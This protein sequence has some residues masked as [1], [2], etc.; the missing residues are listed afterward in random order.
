MTAIPRA[1]HDAGEDAALKGSPLAV[2]VWLWGQ[3]EPHGYRAVVVAT[4]AKKLGMKRE[5]VGRALR[6][7]TAHGYLSEGN[8]DGPY[9]TFRMLVTRDSAHVPLNGHRHAS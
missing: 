4:A 3:L 1:L 5:T 8:R 2:Y 6:I 7:L 9:R